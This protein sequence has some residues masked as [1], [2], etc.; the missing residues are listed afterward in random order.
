MNSNF[1]CL[2]ALSL[3]YRKVNMAR[4][5]LIKELS[6]RRKEIYSEMETQFPELMEE[7]N[8]IDKIIDSS[9]K[10]YLHDSKTT[11]EAESGTPK[12]NMS[13]EEYVLFMLNEIGGVGKS[14][15]VAKAIVNSND[16]ITLKRARDACSD[17][18]SRHLSANRV[19]ATKGISKKDGYIYEIV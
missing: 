1:V 10:L 4:L 2:F 7:L 14:I 9:K 18:L 6:I 16:D 8:A 3:T 12:G 13:W 19:K 15:D 11:N 17:K 5:E